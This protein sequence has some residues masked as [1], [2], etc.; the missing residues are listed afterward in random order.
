MDYHE[1]LAV[2]WAIVADK[3]TSWP[4]CNVYDLWSVQGAG[5]YKQYHIQQY[6]H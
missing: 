4:A 1:S 5:K 6:H 3:Q 2:S